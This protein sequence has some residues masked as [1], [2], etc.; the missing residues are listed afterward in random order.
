MVTQPG[1]DQGFLNYEFV[2]TC[3]DADQ[4]AFKYVESNLAL[5]VL[6]CHGSCYVLFTDGQPEA[7]TENPVQ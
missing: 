2:S 5:S 6:C 3:C 4:T 1:C 7:E